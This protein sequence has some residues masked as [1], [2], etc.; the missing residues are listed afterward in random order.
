GVAGSRIP[1][2]TLIST[3]STDGASILDGMVKRFTGSAPQAQTVDGTP[4]HALAS[5]GFG[6]YYGNVAG[7]FVVT[8]QPRAI[9]AAKG[10]PGSLSDSR[11]F[12]DAKAAS[13]LP[14][15]TWG[16]LYVNISS[17]IPYG[18]ELA[19]ARIP[20]AIARNLKPLRSAVEFAASR[21]HEVQVSFFLRIK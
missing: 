1:E 14:D 3:P 8:D 21:T 16:L 2:I 20:A 10:G 7:E 15:K 17:S 13:G 5:D 12:K 6:L 18:E 4:V 19:H 9:R 11:D